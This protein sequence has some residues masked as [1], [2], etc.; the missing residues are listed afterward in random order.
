I[1]R[2]LHELWLQSAQQI[3][4]QREQKRDNQQTDVRFQVAQ[5]TPRDLEV[6]CLTN[7]FFFVKFSDCG[8][9]AFEISELLARRRQQVSLLREVHKHSDSGQCESKIVISCA[10]DKMDHQSDQRPNFA[11]RPG[12]NVR[13]LDLLKLLL[14]DGLSEHYLLRQE[15]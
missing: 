6:I 8:G 7:R 13:Q 2:V 4:K 14:L 5:Q 3:Q 1:D 9:H 11:Q 10:K 15:R 12:N